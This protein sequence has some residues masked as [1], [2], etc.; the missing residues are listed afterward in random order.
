MPND[1]TL[2]IIIGALA[3]LLIVVILVRNARKKA[4]APAQPAVQLAPEVTKPSPVAVSADITLEF[5]A[6][7]GPSVVYTLNKPLL[8][9]GRAQ[10]NDIVV[11]ES[12]PNFDTVSLHHA[13]LRRDK[14]DYLIR[15]TGSRNGLLVNGRHTQHNLLADGDRLGFGAAEAIFHKPRGGS[16]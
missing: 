1:S 15:D 8:T 5:P 10:D 3:L 2:L 4:A 6:E 11:P 14:D 9:L 7:N 13:Q 16:A 12:V